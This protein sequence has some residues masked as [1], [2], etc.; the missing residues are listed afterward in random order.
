[1]APD[2]IPTSTKQ[3]RSLNAPGPA[4][5]RDTT[6]PQVKR[7]VTD[8]TQQKPASQE[9]RER[10][11]AEGHWLLQKLPPKRRREGAQNWEPNKRER[12]R[13][14]GHMSDYQ[15]PSHEAGRLGVHQPS[16][17]SAGGDNPRPKNAHTHEDDD[18]LIRRKDL[19]KVPAL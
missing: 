9:T 19:S 11:L 5:I 8:A 15:S 18:R 3:S 13:H 10:Y 6:P 12:G 16:H 17:S 1:M 7:P 14:A 2:N 4:S